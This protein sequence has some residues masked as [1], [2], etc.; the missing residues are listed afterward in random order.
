MELRR[1]WTVCVIAL[2]LSLSDPF[3]TTAVGHYRQSLL[4]ATEG[5]KIQQQRWVGTLARFPSS[6]LWPDNSAGEMGWGIQ[7]ALRRTA[8]TVIQACFIVRVI[9]R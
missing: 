4:S 3:T 9:L 2:Y 7:T 8:V 6:C 1:C 5:S